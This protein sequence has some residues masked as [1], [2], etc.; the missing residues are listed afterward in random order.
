M[1]GALLARHFE[2]IHAT[3]SSLII[4]AAAILRRRAIIG[5]IVRY[6]SR[7]AVRHDGLDS[8]AYG[9]SSYTFPRARAAA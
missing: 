3:I 9:K 7:A 1:A 2:A 4:T 8:D 5:R 6:F